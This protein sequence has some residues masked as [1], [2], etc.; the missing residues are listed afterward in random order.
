MRPRKAVR[1]S[2]SGAA[3]VSV[4][5]GCTN[6]QGSCEVLINSRGNSYIIGVAGRTLPIREDGAVHQGRAEILELPAGNMLRV[7]D[8]ARGALV[9]GEEGMLGLLRVE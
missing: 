4:P 9:G 7:V 5:T 8:G 6:A 1:R 3:E 2:G